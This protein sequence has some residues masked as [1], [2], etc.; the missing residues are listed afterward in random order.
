L[1][2]G[3]KDLQLLISFGAISKIGTLAVSKY[4]Y[5]GMYYVVNTVTPKVE[6]GAEIEFGYNKSFGI[7][8]KMRFFA[9]VS[10]GMLVVDEQIKLNLRPLNIG[11]TYKIYS[12]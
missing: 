4:C 3:N 11:F 12:K 5:G 6:H 8:N 2:V 7:D 1:S 10:I 9:G